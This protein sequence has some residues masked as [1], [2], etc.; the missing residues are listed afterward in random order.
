MRIAV[1]ILERSESVEKILR[2]K[3]WVQDVTPFIPKGDRPVFLA[4]F[5][6]RDHFM[7]EIST[8]KHW[9]KLCPRVLV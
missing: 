7:S 8:N 4:R 5:Q 1:A 3:I 6:R 2:I 9:V